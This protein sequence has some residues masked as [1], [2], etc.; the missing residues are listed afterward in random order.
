MLIC[1]VNKYEEYLKM[2]VNIQVC[3]SVTW[4]RNYSLTHRTKYFASFL[5]SSLITMSIQRVTSCQ[6]EVWR[7]PDFSVLYRE[8]HVSAIFHTLHNVLPLNTKRK[9]HLDDPVLAVQVAQIPISAGNGIN[10]NLKKFI[11]ISWFC[12]FSTLDITG[13][14]PRTWVGSHATANVPHQK[15]TDNSSASVARHSYSP[16]ARHTGVL[17]IP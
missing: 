16:A 2:T 15:T 17:I 13:R 14:V 10:V 6:Q 5:P 3:V 8:L 9:Q 4:L 12:A 7:R 1:E 11:Q